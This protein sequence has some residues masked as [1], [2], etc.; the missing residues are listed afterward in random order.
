MNNYYAFQMTNGGMSEGGKILVLAASFGYKMLDPNMVAKTSKIAP[1]I[2]VMDTVNRQVTLVTL[3]Q[4]Q[5]LKPLL[6]ID[7]FEGSA[8]KL[9]HEFID[10]CNDIGTLVDSLNRFNNLAEKLERFAEKRDVMP[11]HPTKQ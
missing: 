1:P 11:Q 3:E 6:G 2:A 9:G 8:E 7:I 4:W 10:S 5:Q